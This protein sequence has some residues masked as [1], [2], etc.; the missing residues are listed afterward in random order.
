MSTNVS[1]TQNNQPAVAKN[2]Q[3]LL[4]SDMVKGR[5]Q[6]IL[7]KRSSTFA[8][9]VIQIANSNDL[10]KKAEPTSIL[11][12]ALLST[13]LDLPLNNS[14]GFAYLV[15]FNN[16]QKDGTYR[17]EAQ[18]QLGAKGIQQLAIRSGQY[19]ELES[20]VV[21]EGQVVEDDSFIGYHFD[22]KAKSSDKVIGYASYFKLLSG[23]STTFYM[24]LAEIEE[25]AK[26]YSQTYKKGFGNW[27]DDFDKMAR[28][29]VMKLLLNSG[30]APLSIEMRNAINADQSV[31][32]N[33]DGEETIDVDYVDNTQPQKVEIS[34]EEKAIAQFKEVLL[35]ISNLDELKSMEESADTF[36]KEEMAL[37]TAKR[38]ELTKK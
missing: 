27:K 35:T 31:V 14:L 29:T 25:H 16:K 12:A 4:Q 26:K 17:V 6:E 5:L 36:T 18:F 13:T 28:K 3:Q 7:G 19:S 1:T 15:P 23:F 37:I 34:D 22:W 33:Y 9:A 11:N 24:T 10:L 21:Y 30:K 2:I 38:K 8:T 32:K 20:K